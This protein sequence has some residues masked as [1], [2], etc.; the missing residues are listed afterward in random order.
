MAKPIPKI[1]SRRDGRI[2]SRISMSSS[3]WAFAG[4]YGFK[5]TKRRRPFVAQT[6]VGNAIRTMV[7]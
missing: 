5:G 4:T 6:A 7:E 2:S 3:F 1:G